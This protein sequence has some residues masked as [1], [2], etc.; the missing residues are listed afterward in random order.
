[1]KVLCFIILAAVELECTSLWDKVRFL[2]PT[3]CDV[4]AAA[5][6]SWKETD[7]MWT[8][9]RCPSAQ[10]ENTRMNS[11]LGIWPCASVAG[12]EFLLMLNSVRPYMTTMC[13]WHWLPRV[14]QIS[15]FFKHI[16]VLFKFCSCTF[17]GIL[18]PSWYFNVILGI[19]P[20]TLTKYNNALSRIGHLYKNQCYK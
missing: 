18:L 4:A 1:M 7:S 5:S 13:R 9:G 19:V 2:F 8:E 16:L 11:S 12:P 17:Q 14:P 15:N 10:L 6:D 20:W 3:A